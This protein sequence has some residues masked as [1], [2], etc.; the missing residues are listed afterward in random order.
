MGKRCLHVLGCFFRQWQVQA[1]AIGLFH[2]GRAVAALRAAKLTRMC[3]C[4]YLGVCLEAKAGPPRQAL[5][6][7]SNALTCAYALL[8]DSGR[9]SLLT[10]TRDPEDVCLH[11][12]MS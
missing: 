2:I 9:A 1:L 12:H 11:L 6:H 4:M 7:V 5:M 10:C 3:L 8:V